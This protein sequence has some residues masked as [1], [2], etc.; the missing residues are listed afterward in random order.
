MGSERRPGNG[1]YHIYNSGGYVSN[2]WYFFVLHVL[3]SYQKAYNNCY[4]R[5]FGSTDSSFNKPSGKSTLSY[6]DAINLPIGI[7]VPYKKN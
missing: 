6:M 3:E 5:F 4:S 7:L 2:S 1:R